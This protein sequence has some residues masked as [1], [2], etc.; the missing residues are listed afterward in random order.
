MN[1]PLKRW[2]ELAAKEEVCM[3]GWE[4]GVMAP[5]PD[6]DI[7]KL[8]AGEL[9]SLAGSYVDAILN[10]SDDYEAFS[11]IRWTPGG[12]VFCHHDNIF[13]IFP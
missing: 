6:F 7:K 13:L 8:G 10:G 2:V 1:L 12:S 3:I 4:D 11:V 5:G 9:R